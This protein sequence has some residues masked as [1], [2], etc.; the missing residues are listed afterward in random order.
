[1]NN[2]EKFW[3]GAVPCQCDICKSNIIDDFVDGRTIYGPWANMCPACFDQVGAYKV[4]ELGTG[5]GQW[6]H[7]QAD[8]RFKKV[9]G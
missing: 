4:Q 1:M 8:G 9:A 5:K 6:Y 7:K 2:K 3:L